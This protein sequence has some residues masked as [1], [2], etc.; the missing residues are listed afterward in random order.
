MIRDTQKVVA[1][2]LHKIWDTIMKEKPTAILLIVILISGSLLVLS[3][4][5]SQTTGE[6]LSAALVTSD[7]TISLN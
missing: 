5:D 7:N 3:I 1:V 4:N 6:K 2:K